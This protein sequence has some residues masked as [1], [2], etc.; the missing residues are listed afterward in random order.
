MTAA[1]YVFSSTPDSGLGLQRVVT[2][3][4][5]DNR[6]T[7][8]RKPAI[9]ALLEEHNGLAAGVLKLVFK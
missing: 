2:Q 6:N 3:N 8:V 1:D 9:G 5:A 7:L 4:I